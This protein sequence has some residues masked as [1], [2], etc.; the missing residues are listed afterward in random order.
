MKTENI[1]FMSAVIDCVRRPPYVQA[2]TMLTLDHATKGRTVT[3]LGAGEQKQM[4]AYGFKRLGASDKMW[5]TVH[6]C[7]KF[8]ESDEPVT[9]EGRKYSVDRAMLAL[10]PYGET[11]PQ[12]WIAG[13]GDEVFHLAGGVADGWTTYGPPGVHG[14]PDKLKEEIDRVHTEAREA[15]KDPED[16][17]ICLQVM[18]ML[19]PDPEVID[20]LRDQAHVRWMSQMVLPTSNMYK[21]WNLGPHPM[22]DDWSYAAKMD[23]HFA[24]SKGGSPGHLQ[25][26]S[27]GSSRS[28][29]L[30]R[31][32][33]GGSGNPEAVPGPR[34][35]GPAGHERRADRRRRGLSPAAGGRDQVPGSR[36]E[37][38]EGRSPSASA[39]LATPARRW[40]SERDY[41]FFFGFGDALHL[42]AVVFVVFLPSVSTMI[43]VKSRLPLQ[44][45]L[46]A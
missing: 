19:H 33:R 32:T 44:A 34:G 46:V 13:S 38:K 41:F 36:V 30:H 18:T 22:G 10:Q 6:I 5:D 42:P 24:L 20:R 27:A 15:G 37:R 39:P 14:S 28:R 7:K 31:I 3:I 1:G 35:H 21:E 17:A 23:R 25:P 45:M 26:H 40:S 11:P 12:I 8:F 16:V 29:L 4:R 43:T 9:Y 2:L